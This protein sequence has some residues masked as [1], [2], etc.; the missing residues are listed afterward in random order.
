MKLTPLLNACAKLSSTYIL[1]AN[2]DVVRNA[3]IQFA[4]HICDQN[5]TY[6]L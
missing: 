2:L 6:G 4:L 5:H 1:I 3:I